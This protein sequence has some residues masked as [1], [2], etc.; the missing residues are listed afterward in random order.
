MVY[1]NSICSKHNNLM[2]KIIHR[3]KYGLNFSHVYYLNFTLYYNSKKIFT[4][5]SDLIPFIVKVIF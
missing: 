4:P 3:F 5:L 1:L 2:I